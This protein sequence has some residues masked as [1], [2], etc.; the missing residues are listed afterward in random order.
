MNKKKD[1]Q[2]DCSSIIVMW[3]HREILRSLEMQTITKTMQMRLNIPRKVTSV[4][5]S[6]LPLSIQKANFHLFASFTFQQ[7]NCLIFHFSFLIIPTVMLH[8]M[9]C[10]VVH[11]QYLPTRTGK[12]CL[13]IDIGWSPYKVVECPV[14][15]SSLC[16]HVTDYDRVRTHH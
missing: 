2:F 13:W 16:H 15:E 6:A 11:I 7:K 5:I 9:L 4:S 8:C 10:F 14:Q 3:T 1:W 12:V